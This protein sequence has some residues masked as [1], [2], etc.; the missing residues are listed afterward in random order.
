MAV[1]LSFPVADPLPDVV[2][3]C[4]VDAFEGA[5]VVV[6]VEPFVI[7]G[8]GVPGDERFVEDLVDRSGRG[9]EMDGVPALEECSDL[10]WS[11]AVAEGDLKN[12]GTTIVGLS[13]VGVGEGG[14]SAELT[15][16]ECC[17]GGSTSMKF[18]FSLS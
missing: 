1:L 14:G 18:S 10:M 5:G 8:T 13:S 6:A 4:G 3:G 15:E 17:R 2:V 11:S 12:E 7:P 9:T 16:A